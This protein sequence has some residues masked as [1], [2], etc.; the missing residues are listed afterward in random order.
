MCSHLPPFSLETQV[1][2]NYMVYSL[3][4]QRLGAQAVIDTASYSLWKFNSLYPVVDKTSGISYII[5]DDERK[6][7]RRDANGVQINIPVLNLDSY[8]MAELGRKVWYMEEF[9][10]VS[11]AEFLDHQRVIHIM[12][13]DY[14]E[15]WDIQEYNSTYRIIS[16]LNVLLGIAFFIDF[17]RIIK[18]YYLSMDRKIPL[19]YNSFILGLG[20]ISYPIKIMIAFDPFYGFLGVIP[21][22]VSR[23]ASSLAQELSVISLLMTSFAWNDILVTIGKSMDMEFVKNRLQKRRVV[24][25]IFSLILLIGDG[26]GGYWGEFVGRGG[27]L[28]IRLPMF[29]SSIIELVVGILCLMTCIRIRSMIKKI[30][31]KVASSMSAASNAPSSRAGTITSGRGVA[32]SATVTGDSFQGTKTVD[33]IK[34]NK[35]KTT[36]S[37]KLDE[38]VDLEGRPSTTGVKSKKTGSNISGSKGASIKTPPPRKSDAFS[39]VKT[40]LEGSIHL[41][42]INAVVLFISPVVWFAMAVMSETW[43]VSKIHLTVLFHFGSTLLLLISFVQMRVVETI[44]KKIG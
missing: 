13:D 33:L 5:Y 43:M 18:K 40:K 26:I 41:M 12:H 23:I 36:G 6:E 20:L 22:P 28:M 32:T 24:L 27:S 29:I 31:N 17:F 19:T 44:S 3:F 4:A 34:N 39:I 2:N 1:L 10:G 38:K 42:Q 14:N 8:Y 35:D 7:L 11:P 21:Q 30:K 9:F 16:Y 25:L 15:M 37:Q